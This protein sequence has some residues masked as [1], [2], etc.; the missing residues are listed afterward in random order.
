ASVVTKPL[1]VYKTDA[2]AGN[3]T[4][5]AIGQPIQLNGSGGELYKWSPSAGL[6][7][8]DIPDPVVILDH[9]AQFVLTAYAAIGC[10][11]TD[12]VNFKVFKGPEIYVPSAFSPTNDGVNDDFRFIAAGMKTIDLFQVYNRYGQLIYSSANITKG[13]DGKLN[14]VKQPPS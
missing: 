7:A 1:R 9:N 2:Y 5:F 12:T 4:I 6:S 3:D 13:W 8:D 14:G 11:T 10:A